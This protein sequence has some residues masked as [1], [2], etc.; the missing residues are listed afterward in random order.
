MVITRWSRRHHMKRSSSK[1]A[2]VLVL[3]SVLVGVREVKASWQT[4]PPGFTEVISCINQAGAFS[5]IHWTNNWLNPQFAANPS[6]T[7]FD[8]RTLGGEP[9]WNYATRNDNNRIRSTKAVV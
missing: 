3:G 7:W 8:S 4:N 6:F 5:P 9:Y 1:V 2:M